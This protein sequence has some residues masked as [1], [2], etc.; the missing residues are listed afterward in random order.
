VCPCPIVCLHRARGARDEGG[1]RIVASAGRR[2]EH[3]GASAS[4]TVAE[5]WAGEAVPD[6]AA[7]SR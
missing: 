4:G 7:A 1:G 2:G 6:S 3:R 5:V